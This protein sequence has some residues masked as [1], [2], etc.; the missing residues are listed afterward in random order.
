MRGVG[1]E[2]ANQ[3]GKAWSTGIGPPTPP[4]TLKH[5]N[6]DAKLACCLRFSAAVLGYCKEFS[7]YHRGGGRV[8]MAQERRRGGGREYSSS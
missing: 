1:L 2:L 5:R 7:S 8:T 6:P 4:F 3:N